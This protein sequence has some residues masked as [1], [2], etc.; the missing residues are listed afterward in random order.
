[1]KPSNEDNYDDVT[2]NI[3][4]NPTGAYKTKFTYQG[5]ECN[6]QIKHLNEN[7][8]DIRIKTN[9][10]MSEEMLAGLKQYLEAEG[11]ITQALKH[12]LFW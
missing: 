11:Y 7:E 9:K 2:E 5:I 3:V 8:M 6:I 10:K 1:M 4:T 12:N